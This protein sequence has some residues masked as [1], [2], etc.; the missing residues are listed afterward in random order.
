M[1]AKAALGSRCFELDA[2]PAEL[3]VDYYGIE[4]A[5]LQAVDEATEEAKASPPPSLDLMDQDVWADGGA[6]W[7]N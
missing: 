7:R 5:V 2:A 3:P 6:S 1:G 4:E